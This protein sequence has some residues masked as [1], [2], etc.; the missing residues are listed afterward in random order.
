MDDTPPLS[1]AP[2]EYM[3]ASPHGGRP[4]KSRPWWAW[5]RRRHGDLDDHNHGDQG[6]H[7]NGNRPVPGPLPLALLSLGVLGMGGAV[8]SRRR[9]RKPGDAST[10]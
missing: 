3:E 10:G 4:H 1:A 7:G 8:R 5:W 9:K 2:I 6:G